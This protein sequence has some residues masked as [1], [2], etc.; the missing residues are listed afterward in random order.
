MVVEQRRELRDET[1]RSGHTS[2]T[3]TRAAAVYEGHT[4]VE[5]Q[6]GRWQSSGGTTLF[7]K[8]GKIVPITTRLIPA[9]A[10]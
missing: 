5:C 7:S 3:D 2:C 8:R 4:G 9:L 10:E 6:H 1:V